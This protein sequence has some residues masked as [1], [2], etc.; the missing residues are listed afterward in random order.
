MSHSCGFQ[1]RRFRT[2]AA[3]YARFRLG[4]PDTLIRR[5]IA[6]TE[7]NA[8]DPVLDLGAGPGLLALPFAEAGMAVTAVDPEPEMLDVLE[9]AAKS[10]QLTVRALAGSSFAMPSGIGPFRLVTIGRAFHWMDRVATLAEL[11]RLVVPG[12]AL[13]L[14]EDVNLKTVENRWRGVLDAVAARFG[15]DSAPHRQER[16][17]PNQRAHESVLQ[18]SPFNRLE[19]AGVVVQRE[20][21][22]DDIVGLAGSQSVTLPQALGDRA[23]AFE[24]EL[25][26]ALA[27]LSPD[28]RFVQIAEMRA[29][30]ARR[31]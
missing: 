18:S 11:D 21:S 22:V 13:A 26:H 17:D 1:A 4:Y 8:G 24:A 20:L 3:G 15:A 31:S 16:A 25:R 5:V 14:F 29:L 7:L 27:A 23:A 19:T 12:G 6:L 9:N 10:A 2:A 30:V 28:G